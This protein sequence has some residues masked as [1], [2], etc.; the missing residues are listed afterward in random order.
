MRLPVRFRIL[1]ILVTLFVVSGCT[2]TQS[3]RVENS[4]DDDL[5]VRFSVDHYMEAY[6]C[7]GN[8]HVGDFNREGLFTIE[9]GD[10]MCLIAEV[11]KGDEEFDI[12]ER[13][14]NLTLIRNGERCLYMT[15]DELLPQYVEQGGRQVF[16]VRNSLCPAPQAA[17]LRGSGAATDAEDAEVDDEP[18]ATPPPSAPAP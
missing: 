2:K 6:E 17:P 18:G 12:R 11:P 10:S 16:E 3:V 4:T 7:K 15:S 5:F 9:S 8:V 14:R 13:V 1:A